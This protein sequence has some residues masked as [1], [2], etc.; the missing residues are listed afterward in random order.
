MASGSRQGWSVKSSSSPDAWCRG[1]RS[2]GSGL[3]VFPTRQPS[4]PVVYRI[5]TTDMHSDLGFR[6][7][8]TRTQL[9]AVHLA[10]KLRPNTHRHQG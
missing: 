3:A 2:G 8:L 7:L 5:R 10:G 6:A 4:Y 9:D 1:F